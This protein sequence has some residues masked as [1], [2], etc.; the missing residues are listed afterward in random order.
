MDRALR[1]TVEGLEEFLALSAL[2][3][4]PLPEI[5]E[6]FAGKARA[7]GLSIA[8]IM[9]GWRLLDPLF[10]S[11]TLFWNF[12]EGTRSERYRHGE[13][14]VATDYQISPI[15]T[16]LESDT[17]EIRR[18]FDGANAPYEYPLYEQLAAAGITDYI[19]SKVQYGKDTVGD[20]P[21]AGMV[22]SFGSDRRDGFTDDE[23][24]A[25]R[26]IKFMIALMLRAVMEADMRRTLANTYLGRVAAAR[27]LGGEISRGDGQ[28]VDA[29]IW[30]C[31]LRGST[32]LCE[33]M[34]EGAYI[35]LL[36][37]Y[38]TATAGPVIDAGGEVLDFI[39]DA[40]LAVFPRTKAGFQQ[41]FSATA[42]ALEALERFMALH[43]Q[44][45]DRA[46]VAD[47]T[48][49]AMDAGRVVYGN[50]GTED[51]LTFSVI[52]PTVNK[53]ARLEALTKSLREPVLVTE[54]VARE[55]PSRW[56]S[57]G[58]FSLYGV[59]EPHH[60]YAPVIKAPAH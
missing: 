11:Q 2:Q 12:G 47:I 36:N 25:L 20:T 22:A 31:D 10:L 48:G 19:I 16:I 35:D 41:A 46:I 45:S 14:D 37:D 51:R 21:G 29:I 26:R 4:R 39:G 27:V 53:V 42:K 3:T 49:I 7:G 54:E 5:I 52:G 24:E 40:V 15:R 18:R 50:I 58:T 32:A 59:A 55:E 57:V 30:Y 1:K 38:F 17:Q 8:R 6:E 56:R 9:L 13:A 33:A 43:P 60:V 23:I 44:L 34:D 28:R